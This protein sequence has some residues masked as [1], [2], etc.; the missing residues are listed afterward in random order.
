[1][2]KQGLRVT[3]ALVVMVGTATA[4]FA[5]GA[6]T[7]RDALVGSYYHSGLL[8]QNR[9]VLRA[10]DEDVAQAV[11]ALRPILN[12]SAELSRSFGDTRSSSTGFLRI[13]INT[14]AL[15]LG[16]SAQLLL[17]DN[18][19]TKLGIEAVKE[20]VLATRQQLIAVEQQV[21]L[22]AVSAYFN[23]RRAAE[24]VTLRRNN[25]RVLTE[26][27]R[28]A[29]DRFEVGEVTRTDVAQAQASLAAARSGLASAMGDLVQA[30]EEYANVVGRKPGQLAA[31]GRLPRLETQI[32]RAKEI[33]VRNHPSLKQVQHQVAAADIRVEAAKRSASPTVNAVGTI[34]LSDNLNNRG[35]T[36][37]YSF[38]IEASGPIYQG[39]ALASVTRQAIANRDAQRGL[40]HT[41][42]H[43][44]R[45]DVGNAYASLQAATAQLQSTEEQ[46]RA[47]RVAFRGV[48]EEA[49]LGARTTLDVLNAEQDL[50]DAQ[51]ARI[52]AEADRYI[53]AYSVLSAMGQLTV[54]GLGL[55]IQQYDP[56]SY[57]DLVK[58]AP[59][60]SSAQGKKLDRV[61]KSLQKD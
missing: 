53:A 34:G 20:V 19:Q 15:E 60:A 48:R 30:Q 27:L 49:T 40:L 59:V 9:A 4:P 31:P 61:L 38:G 32:P 26:Q 36:N 45:Q 47:A 16:L 29:E 11:A 52:S 51:A 33:A 8:D 23:V 5:A 28:A 6:E 25:L 41:T 43:D 17:W 56:S 35:R 22:R 3:R 18:A 54:T 10:A 55:G 13:G 42:R 24:N 46:I 14:T 58:T 44:I 2:L 37:S 21:F 50:L 39:G 12:W 1:M 57:Y 7:L